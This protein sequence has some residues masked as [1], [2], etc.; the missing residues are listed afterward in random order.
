M[1]S[2][3]GDRRGA[4][5]HEQLQR[6]VTRRGRAGGRIGADH[7]VDGHRLVVLALHVHDEPGALERRL[8]VVRRLRGDVGDLHR[9][10]T[11]R[12]DEL[13]LGVVGREGA[14]RGML[15]DHEA[16]G[17]VGG[18]LGDVQ[19][20]TGRHDLLRRRLRREPDE[21]RHL[22]GAPGRG[23]GQRHTPTDQREED[24]AEHRDRHPP[25][26]AGRTTALRLHDRNRLGAAPLDATTSGR[27]GRRGSTPRAGSAS[28]PHRRSHRRDRRAGAVAVARAHAP[29]SASAARM[30]AASG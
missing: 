27:P 9:R 28:V 18:A 14:R 4:V 7:R 22:R 11:T 24:R 3:T 15:T 2:G 30:V 10:R 1:T 26:R 23:R 5:A 12:H 25:H 16:G 13:D 8:R 29:A 20:E 21:R 19:R 17:I 6:R